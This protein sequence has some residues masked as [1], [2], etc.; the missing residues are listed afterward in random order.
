MIPYIGDLSRADAALLHRFGFNAF[1]ILEFGCGA[2]TQIF[3]AYTN[4]TVDSVETDP[5]WIDKTKRNL[6]AL[7]IPKP[8]AFHAYA[9]FVP[10]SYDLIFVD[11]IDQLR[12]AFAFLTWPHLEAGGFMLFHDTRRT[13]PHGQST[14]SDIENA[15]STA[16]EF[17]PEVDRVVLNQDGS[18]ITVLTKRSAPLRYEDWNAVEGRTLEQIGIA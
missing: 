8:V 5:A 1:R 10:K 15:L 18:N 16:C 14:T 3:A 11:G 9:R 17:S 13:K 6:G 12:R 2:S 4:G 7:A